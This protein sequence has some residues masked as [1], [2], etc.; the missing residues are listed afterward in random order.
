MNE[1]TRL[2]G[3][4]SYGLIPT[5]MGMS[6]MNDGKGNNNGDDALPDSFSIESYNVNYGGRSPLT[7]SVMASASPYSRKETSNRSPS[8]PS[9]IF[10]TETTPTW[11]R[12]IRGDTT[13]THRYPHIIF[14]H[15]PA[16][17][18]MAIL[19]TVPIQSIE[20]LPSA[21]GWFDSCL[22][23]VKLRTTQP[24]HI[25][26]EPIQLDQWCMMYVLNVHLRPASCAFGPAVWRTRHDREREVKHLMNIIH[27]KL[28]PIDSELSGSN[29]ARSRSPTRRV[30]MSDTLAPLII[31]GDFNEDD[32]PALRLLTESTTPFPSMSSSPTREYPPLLLGSSLAEHQPGAPTWRMR[33]YQPFFTCPCRY[34]VTYIFDHILY[35]SHFMC[36]NARSIYDGHSDHLPVVASFVWRGS[37]DTVAYRAER[38][39]RYQRGSRAPIKRWCK[40][41]LVVAIIAAIIVAII[42]ATRA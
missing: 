14:H 24:R 35:S 15:A 19:S 42:Y 1:S 40:R 18:G 17:G 7:L 39:N 37:N 28:T 12:L 31:V 3:Q 6:S 32:G 23:G 41:I 8:Y 11:E 34:D 5:P 16:A 10:L 2:S 20:W 21:I 4:R 38:Q 27:S 26:D 9:M 22:V 33:A 30:G 29:V 36:T 13:L 25:G